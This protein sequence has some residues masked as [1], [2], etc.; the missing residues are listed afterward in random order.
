MLP[1]QET[2]VRHLHERG[3]VCWDHLIPKGCADS[4]CTLL[5]ICAPDGT[6][7]CGRHLTDM[8]CLWGVTRRR[9]PP[10]TGDCGRAH[11]P[12]TELVRAVEAAAAR[13]GQRLHMRRHEAAALSR[14]T[15][16][17]DHTAPPTTTAPAA[18][19]RV[20]VAHAAD[21]DPLGGGGGG[22]GDEWS[23]HVVPQ[24][25]SDDEVEAVLALRRPRGW[26]QPVGKGDYLSGAA[27]RFS[28]VWQRP[29]PGN[30]RSGARR[31]TTQR[32]N[33]AQPAASSTP[34]LRVAIDLAYD[35][36]MTESERRSL[37]TQVTPICTH[38][39][40]PVY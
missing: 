9:R 37:A 12:L 6:P 35:A 2:A 13:C 3:V 15:A 38:L 23:F 1:Q 29:P 32:R 39:H 27:G 7:E 19:E 4:S 33:A 20:A 31:S 17:L 24:A 16:L 40:Q 11:L 14:W 22:S 5:H 28:G 21:D 8:L 36:A 25:L 34:R 26:R 30:K 10:C 18:S